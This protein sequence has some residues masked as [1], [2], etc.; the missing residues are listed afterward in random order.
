VRIHKLEIQAFGPFAERQVIDFDALGEAG[1]FLLNG[2]T[3]AG[4]T[5]VLDAICYALYGSVPGAR[6]S[7]KRLRSDHAPEGLEPRVVCEFSARGRWMEVMRSPAWERPTKRGSGTTVAQ[8]QTQL[9][10]RENGVWVEKSGRNDEAGG[11]ITALLGMSMDQFTKVVLLAQGDFAAFLRS[12]ADERQELLQKLFGTEL[13]RN[14]ERQLAADAK[15]AK[16]GLDAKEQQLGQLVAAA[17]A[18]A[19]NVIAAQGLAELPP[20]GVELFTVL[21]QGLEE[22]HAQAASAALAA[23]QGRL[24][25]TAALQQAEELSLRH[26]KLRAAAAERDRLAGLEPEHQRWLKRIGEHREAQVLAGA[27]AAAAAAEAKLERA[28][29]TAQQVCQRLTAD[30]AAMSLAGLGG[31]GDLSVAVL[32]GAR[33]ELDRAGALVEALLPEES[34]LTLLRGELERIS[35]GIQEAKTAAGSH[36][37]EARRAEEKLA[38]A[39]L[40]VEGLRELALSVDQRERAAAAATELVETIRSHRRAQAA[41]QRCEEDHLQARQRSLAAKARWLELMALRLERA[42]G[43]MAARLVDGEACPVCGSPAHPHPSPLAGTGLK[44]AEEE[45]RAKI[46]HDQAEAA[47]AAVA[48][49]LSA[50][51]QDLAVLQGRGG[52]ADLETSEQAAAAAGAALLEATRAAAE[53][54]EQEAT[55]GTLAASIQEHEAMAAKAREEAAGLGATLTGRQAQVE[56]LDAKLAESR[57]GHH[58]LA[59]RLAEL[60]RAAVLVA[61]AVAAIAARDIAGTQ[62]A[63]AQDALQAALPGTPFADAA[64]A[65]DALL[66]AAEAADLTEQIRIFSEAGVRAKAA[67]EP[68][69][70]RQAV[71]EVAEGIVVPDESALSGLRTRAEAAAEAANS[72]A[73]V[74]ELA[75]KALAAV[76]DAAG[77]HTLL[78]AEAAPLREQYQRIAA[79]A[80][81][82]RGLGENSYKMTLN[83]YVLA[84]RLE[85]VAIAAS[86]RLGTMSDGRYTL[87]H[88]DALAGRNQ[89]SGLGLEVVDQW[90]GQ[91]RD[92]A[93]LSGGESFMASLA[94]AL[95]LADVVQ[96]ESGGIDIETLFVDEG[97]GSLDE[98]SLEQVMD[99]LEGLR[100]GGRVVGLVS[101]VAEMKL[102]IPT[103][104]QVHKGRTGSTLSISH[105]AAAMV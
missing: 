64:A 46:E 57:A 14:V 13:Y 58:S 7:G 87:S 80:E 39:R 89:K 51:R 78:E 54:R 49:K 102:R 93:T 40:A 35:A 60:Q 70:V 5:S 90:T 91:R 72:A 103:Q 38:L 1:L 17:R 6:Q 79:L 45:D 77:G 86:Q 76:R 27:L 47:E 53:L 73:V 36:D 23:R 69:D 19:G 85:Q 24:D 94:L 71:V 95:G 26:R 67:F 10:E 75:E 28:E 99:A 68:E 97:F 31:G 33:S 8:A 43:E 101:H 18:Q 81:T 22:A 20:G 30:A 61:E 62:A 100:D 82:A 105:A 48:G 3:G 15:A 59:D 44:A 9:R 34:R 4:K 104:L 92:T 50:A 88:S 84:A 55:L 37:G 32:T 98:Q 11:E 66:P 74:R 16:D 65:R 2:P 29:S 21:L 25:A 52:A 12:K 41:A 63:T 56:Q 83:T 42:A 96:Q